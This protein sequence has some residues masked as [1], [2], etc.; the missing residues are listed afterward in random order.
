MMQGFFTVKNQKRGKKPAID[1]GELEPVSSLQQK[2][3]E[4]VLSGLVIVV[5]FIC[6]H[7]STNHCHILRRKSYSLL[8]VFTLAFFS[9]ICYCGF[10]FVL[11]LPLAI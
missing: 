3:K 5:P 6:S 4:N 7:D 2:G 11:F 1:E 8:K 9:S 10:G